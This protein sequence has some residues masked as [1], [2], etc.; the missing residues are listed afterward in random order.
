MNKID[1]S[2]IILEL[3]NFKKGLSLDQDD[4]ERQITFHMSLLNAD[5]LG[6]QHSQKRVVENLNSKLQPFTYDNSVKSLLEGL[7]S[8]I[9]NDEL[10]YELEDLYRLLENDNQGMLYRHVMKIVLD[11][12]NES[13]VRNQEIK[14]LN[15]LSIH[16]WIPAVKNFMFKRTTDP[17]ERQNIT[18][19]GGKSDVVY[20]IVEKINT[21]DK[22]GYLTYI[23]DKWFFI[24]ESNIDFATPSDYIT[25]RQELHS[26]NLLQKA[27]E[28][29]TIADKKI[30]FTIDEDLSL[31]ISVEN[32]DIFINNEKADK[33]ATLESVFDS[34]L[35]PFMRKDLYPIVLETIKKL[36]NFVEL[37]IVQK[38]TNITVPY[39]ENYVFNYKNSMFSY[40]KDTRYGSNLYQYDSATVLCNEVNSK[41]GYDLSDFLKNKFTKE[42]ADRKDL[43]N[44]EKFISN[45]LSE[46]SECI[47]SLEICGL[48][49]SSDELKSAL[50]ALISE[51]S[52]FETELFNVK[53][54]L[55][56][57]K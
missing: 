54:L 30:N 3:H 15:E 5:D 48:L 39:L 45:K 53:S 4:I 7:N 12:I 50:D 16:D 24:S 23:G 43:E 21:E 33:S 31:S 19:K 20:S 51:K 14:I 26:I 36:D 10:F 27:L 42:V 17:R 1:N 46:V 22:N 8:F 55:A 44:K 38:I 18:S 32:G 34:A 9:K 47:S 13:N 11:I 35:I 6:K 41:L 25:D 2:D 49:E 56:N 40:T 28:I 52:N 29:G 57:N 37:D